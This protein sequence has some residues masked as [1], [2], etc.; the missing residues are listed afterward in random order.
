MDQKSQAKVMALGF[1][2]IRCDDYPSIRIKY[3]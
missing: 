1:V 2:I 3:K